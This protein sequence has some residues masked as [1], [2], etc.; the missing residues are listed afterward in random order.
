MKLFP[1]NAGISLLR[2]MMILIKENGGSIEVSKLADES[3]QNVDNLLPL[4]E[5]SKM[6]GLVNVDE[7]EIKLTPEGKRMDMHN[8]LEI[9][10]K[11]IKGIEPFKSSLEML[12]NSNGTAST[13]ELTHALLANGIMLHGDFKMNKVLLKSM[14]LK[15]A[16]RTNLL[17]YKEDE[18]A[19]T[20]K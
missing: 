11:K 19:W 18:D 7:G 3:E 2:G 10:S 17:E 12:A 1:P 5:A 20:L 6:L 9:L 8:F 4:I 16:V 14:L 13:D 15:W